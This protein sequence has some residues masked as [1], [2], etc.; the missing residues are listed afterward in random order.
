MESVYSGGGGGD[1]IGEKNS[2]DLF[3]YDELLF[4]NNKQANTRTK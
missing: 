1:F 4:Q 2:D 3:K